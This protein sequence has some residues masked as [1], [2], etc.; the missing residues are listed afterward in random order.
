MGLYNRLVKYGNKHPSDS[1]CCIQY[2]R[3]L[4]YHPELSLKD[5]RIT[6]NDVSIFLLLTLGVRVVYKLGNIIQ[7]IEEMAL[8]CQ[9]AKSSS[10]ALQRSSL[11]LR[12]PRCWT[13]YVGLISAKRFAMAV[14]SYIPTRSYRS[15]PP[16]II[17]CI[18]KANT[19]FPDLTLIL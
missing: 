7:D 11:R 9:A 19:L 13:S 12:I 16:H 14:I 6:R 1:R 17:E 18:R 5:L 8:L 3:Y 15:Y 10:S 4:R 2:L